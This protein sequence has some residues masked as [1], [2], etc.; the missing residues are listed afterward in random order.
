[1]GKKGLQARESGKPYHTDSDEPNPVYHNSPRCP[2][3]L[4][5]KRKN[6]Q[7]GADGR[8][9]CDVCECLQLKAQARTGT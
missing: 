3:G 9:L 5:I 7:P 1:M 8:P 4:Q 6:L 2:D